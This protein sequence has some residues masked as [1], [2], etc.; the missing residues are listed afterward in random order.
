[1]SRKL[2]SPFHPSCQIRQSLLLHSSHLISS[3]APVIFA[4]K[5]KVLGSLIK[6]SI[7]RYDRCALTN[8]DIIDA[9]FGFKQLKLPG[10]ELISFP[11]LTLTTMY[12]SLLNS[13]PSSH[14]LAQ[15]R[16]NLDPGV[17]PTDEA[18]AFAK[19]SDFVAE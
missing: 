19:L 14:R 10:T 15:R 4:I 1:M 13:H 8:G 6:N 9:A 5:H 7:H 16:I 11:R 12:Q 2:R 17:A 18:A 3:A